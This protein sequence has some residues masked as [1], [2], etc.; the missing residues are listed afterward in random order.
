MLR[1]RFQ[2][3][4]FQDLLESIVETENQLR[5]PLS[6]AAGVRLEKTIRAGVRQQFERGGIPAWPRAHPFGDFTPASITLG[7]TGGRVARAWERAQ[8]EK[9]PREVRLRV[10]DKIALAHHRGALIKPRGEA[11]VMRAGL[12]RATGVWMSEERLRAGLRL[13]QRAIRYTDEMLL[14]AKL[15]VFAGFQGA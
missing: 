13:P 7:S 10:T 6:G 5:R 4:G 3:I 12:G 2:R 1:F 14:A 15:S 9:G 8:T 11:S